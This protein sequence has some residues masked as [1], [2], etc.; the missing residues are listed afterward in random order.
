MSSE[1]SEGGLSWFE[2]SS[3]ISAV[4]AKQASDAV[5]GLE[6]F[7][8]STST[9]SVVELRTNHRIAP[10]SDAA[11]ATAAAAT[12]AEDPIEVM[13]KRLAAKEAEL[14]RVKQRLRRG[15][16]AEGEGLTLPQFRTKSVTI[17][18]NEVDS[19]GTVPFA[20]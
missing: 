15:G 8:G 13:R 17:S 20:P 16:A 2:W 6:V 10:G 1:I 3:R 9:S 12:A 18:R 7:T 4:H 5:E 11:A 19:F 14:E